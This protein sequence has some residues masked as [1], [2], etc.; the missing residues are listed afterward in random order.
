MYISFIC[1]IAHTSESN[2]VKVLSYALWYMKIL[3]N[4]HTFRKIWIPSSSISGFESKENKTLLPQIRGTVVGLISYNQSQLAH[5]QASNISSINDQCYL[6]FW[7]CI[8]FLRLCVRSA[9]LYF[10]AFGIAHS[11]SIGFL[12]LSITSGWS[13]NLITPRYSFASPDSLSFLS[14]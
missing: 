6:I 2:I 8:V 10:V 5:F 4:E 9:Y 14:P 12:A 1:A 7:T 3:D 11:I 13:E